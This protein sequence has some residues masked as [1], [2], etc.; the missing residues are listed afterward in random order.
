MSDLASDGILHY[1]KRELS[2]LRNQGA[3]FAL[4]YPKVASRL[5]LH[6]TESPDPHTERLIEAT[7]F[8]AARVHRDLD[9]EFPQIAAAMLDNVCPTLVQPIPSMTVVQLALDGSQGKVTAGLP[10]ARH[11]GLAAR[12]E[13]GELC[14]FRTAWDTTLWPL[15]MV[16]AGFSEDQAL[17]LELECDAG[18]E[19]S[20]LEIRTLRIHLQ[21]D[22][23]VTMPLYELLA[24]GVAGISL[25]A[26][27]GG[28][29]PL[30]LT[31][32]REVGY[33]PEDSVLPQPPHGLPAHGL[34]QEYF[35]FPRKFHF[36][37]LD[38]PRGLPFKGRRCEVALH[39]DRRARGLGA[40]GA[41]HF[42]LGCTPVIN[43]YA[44]TSEPVAIDDSHYEYRLVADKRRDETTEVHSVLS[45]ILSD[46]AAERAIPVPSYA[47]VEH[48]DAARG[49]LF[50]SARREYSLRDRVGGTDMFLSFVDARNEIRQPAEPVVY[51]NLLCTNRRLAEQVPVGARMVFER[52]AQNVSVQCLYEPTAQRNPPLG[53]DA[54]WRLV[55]LLTLNQQ[56]LVDGATGHKRLQQILQLFA[57]GSTREQDLIRGLKGVSSR[58]VTAHVGKEA[59]RGFC[60]GTE[61]T[62]E[63]DADAFVGGSPL[64]LGAVLAR[65][66]AMYTS[67]NSFVRLAVRRGDETWKQWQPMTGCQ[68]SL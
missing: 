14:R 28:V 22:W 4:R 5:A 29:A 43:L 57:S 49:T 61:V 12:T 19:L 39:L 36:F 65:F 50:W 53:S 52:V 64:L 3:D 62:V 20:E 10:V 48:A 66:F 17:R 31:A 67:V 26:E 41:Q 23:M 54:L 45:V 38:L 60:H 21:G 13:A 1:Y 47:E 68:Q 34:M 56:S 2:Y 37:D 40:I 8:L 32:W 18:V 51:A 6:G 46:P 16:G 24:A 35:A 63:F 44:Q 11:S 15:K 27:G 7:A 25:Y 9:Q 58:P 55:S 42:R 59:W 30:P 33:A